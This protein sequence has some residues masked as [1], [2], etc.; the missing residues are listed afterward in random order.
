MSQANDNWTL[1]IKPKTNW[2]NLQLAEL[3]RHRDLTMIFV[4]RDFVA[5]Y[6]QTILGPLWYLVQPVIT[7]L[8]MTLVFSKVAHVSTE[9]L[10]PWLFNLCGVATW[11]YFSECL[12]RTSS[13]FIGNA[14]LFGKVYFPR[15]CVPLS[16]VI[17]GLIRFAIQFGLFLAVAAYYWLNDAHLRPNAW[18]F[19]TPVLLL[20]MAGLGLGTGIIVS[21]L[22]TRY[23]DLQQL[24]TFGVQLLMFGT[25]VYYPLSYVPAKYHWFFLANPLTPVFETF[26]HAFLGAGT[27]TPLHLVYS[28]GVTVVV[29]VVG[30]LLFH[31]VE[32]TFM[33]TV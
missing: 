26:R 31:H 21:A 23:R 13:T 22:T 30:V 12:N 9:G 32:R 33:D 19:L 10:P 8:T 17:S 7:A 27:I 18:V 14:H 15:L 5:T 2:L 20:V 4:W 6:K 16:L 28:V 11:G 24:V 29:L 1:I 25:P 3:W